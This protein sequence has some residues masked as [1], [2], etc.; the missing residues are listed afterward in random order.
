MPAFD[1]VSVRGIGSI[2]Y[3][4]FDIISFVDA[5]NADDAFDNCPW[6]Y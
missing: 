1:G 6:P 2:K 3:H 5:R 4:N